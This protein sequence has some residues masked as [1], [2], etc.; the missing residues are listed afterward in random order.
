MRLGSKEGLELAQKSGVAGVAR[1]VMESEGG[2]VQKFTKEYAKWGGVSS[3][4]DAIRYLSHQTAL[5]DLLQRSGKT[6]SQVVAE[7]RGHAYQAAAYDAVLATQHTYGGMG[8][9]PYF[10]HWLG[11]PLSGLLLQFSQYPGFAYKQTEMLAKMAA[12]NPGALMRYFAIGG[13]LLRT[14]DQYHVDASR[15][16]GMGY[17]QGGS[18]PGGLINSPTANMLHEMQGFNEALNSDDPAKVKLAGDRAGSWLTQALP[19]VSAIAKAHRQGKQSAEMEVRGQKGDFVRSLEPGEKIPT[20]LGLPTVEGRIH[21]QIQEQQLQA[22][23]DWLSARKDGTERFIKRVDS[24]DLDGAVQLAEELANMGIPLSSSMLEAQTQ[25]R[26]VGRVL[27]TQLKYVDILPP[28]LLDQIN[29]MSQFPQEL[30]PE[31]EQE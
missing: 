17:L 14:L 3:S 24:G 30:Q 12:Q 5:G 18:G 28:E 16:V 20:A 25:A 27:R 19:G 21:R 8:R 31:P 29:A 1:H 26:Y 15:T 13:V 7:G 6:W 2:F 11:K 9:S 22:A 23:R 4:E 10:D